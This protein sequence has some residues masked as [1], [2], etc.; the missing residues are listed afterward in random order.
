MELAGEDTVQSAPILPLNQDKGFNL[1]QTLSHLSQGAKTTVLT[2]AG[3]LWQT[4]GHLPQGARITV[5]TFTGLLLMILIWTFIDKWVIFRQPV[6]SSLTVIF[7][8][9]ERMGDRLSQEKRSGET[10]YEFTSLLQRQINPYMS[11]P[12]P[13]RIFGP[14]ILEMQLITR[15][16]VQATFSQHIPARNEALKAFA[17]WNNLRWRLSLIRFLHFFG[18][19]R[20]NQTPP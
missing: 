6:A 14:G 2:F 3:L 11:R 20:P 17:A 7:K 8:R 10:P 5:L 18:R 9:M 1:W 4:L 16:Y 12:F 15:L 13:A 19:K